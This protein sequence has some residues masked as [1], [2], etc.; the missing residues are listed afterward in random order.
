MRPERGGRDSSNA[1]MCTCERV[2][3]EHS[4]LVA[5]TAAHAATGW[6]STQWPEVRR[7]RRGSVGAMSTWEHVSVMRR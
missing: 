1:C 3:M 5:W 7:G 6:Q 2:T 4:A